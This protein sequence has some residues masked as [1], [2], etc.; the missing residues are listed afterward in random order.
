MDINDNK[1]DGHDEHSTSNDARNP[2]WPSNAIRRPLNDP[3]ETEKDRGNRLHH[4]SV[5]RSG[6]G[7]VRSDGTDPV[8]SD[9]QLTF[10]TQA[11]YREITQEASYHM[12]PLPPPEMLMEYK[13]ID[14]S[15]V[16][17]IIEMARVNTIGKHEVVKNLA[18]AEARGIRI[19]AWTTPVLGFGSLVSAVIFGYMGNNAGV[20]G[21]LAATGLLGLAKIASAIRGPR[22][23]Q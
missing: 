8:P 18:S 15:L 14:P 10:I 22:D 3:G 23:E 20:V 6:P 5:E 16:P 1:G 7:D 11:E 21:S 2:S 17:T 12:G 4:G 13:R 9:D 19:I